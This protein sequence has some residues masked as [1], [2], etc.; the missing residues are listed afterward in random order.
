MAAT[1]TLWAVAATAHAT[2]KPLRVILPV[3]AGSGVDTII[4]AAG[5]S[6]TKALGGQPI[7]IENLPGAGGTTGTVQVVRAAPDGQTI[8][9]VSNNHVV[10]PS[11]FKKMPFDAL[12]D[13]TPISV[14][15]ATPFVLVVNPGQV[16]AKNAK[17]LQA[18]LKAK[19][20]TY[21]YGSSGN[22]TIIHLAGEMFV[23]AA[24]VDVRHIP[25]KGVG[26]MVA[27]LIGGQVQLGVVALPAVVGHLKSG[28]LR[29][30]GIMGKQR[31]AALPDLPTVAEQGFP[32]VDIA[33]WFAVI[34]P[35]RMP[36]AEV[37]RLHT[38]VVN[39]F[40]LPE[41]KEAMA[42]QENVINPMTPEASAQFFKTEQERYA[43][44]AK[45]A[46]ITLE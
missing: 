13:I 37:K 30:I 21:N 27:D 8:G 19:P 14:V 5:P 46:N 31:V 40:A 38:A 16:P 20:G 33:G 35:A 9:V 45:K 25:Y 10:N 1:L 12:N 41:A 32:D 6:L 7:I 18:F 42:K 23:D 22:G 26:P 36:P 34:G 4:R 39:A 15:G 24:G 44:L 28:A 3:G 2:D 11:V 29:A 17:E 43:R